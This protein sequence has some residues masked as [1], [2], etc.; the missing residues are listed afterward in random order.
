MNIVLCM[1]WYPNTKTQGKMTVPCYIDELC[2]LVDQPLADLGRLVTFIRDN[3]AWLGRNKHQDLLTGRDV[4]D[5]L[6]G[7]DVKDS[8]T[9]R[10]RCG[11]AQKHFCDTRILQVISQHL[12]RLQPL[13]KTDWPV[14]KNKKKLCR[15]LGNRDLEGLSELLSFVL[16]DYSAS[17]PPKSDEGVNDAALWLYVVMLNLTFSDSLL[18]HLCRTCS[19]YYLSIGQTR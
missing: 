2:H 16:D 15:G 9:V 4:E 6:T 1:S 12:A 11:R 5:S 10:E 3:D 8:L 17:P 14:K 18:Q 19:G 7:R 13:Y